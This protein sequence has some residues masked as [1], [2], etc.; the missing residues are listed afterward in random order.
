[1]ENCEDRWLL[2]SLVSGSDDGWDLK[3]ASSA[4]EETY[5]FRVISSEILS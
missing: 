4:G 2:V 5:N 3:G 1:M